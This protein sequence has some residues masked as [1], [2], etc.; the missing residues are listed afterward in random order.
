[1]WSMQRRGS[2]GE[3]QG[4]NVEGTW[5]GYRGTSLTGFPAEQLILDNSAPISYKGRT[6]TSLV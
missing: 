4:A 3:E 5:L 2:R 6:L 1:M